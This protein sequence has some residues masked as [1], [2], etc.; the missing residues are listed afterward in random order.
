MREVVCRL[1]RLHWIYIDVTTAFVRETGSH[2]TVHVTVGLGN[3]R[4][5]TSYARK[6]PW[7]CPTLVQTCHVWFTPKVDGRYLVVFCCLLPY[8]TWVTRFKFLCVRKS[9]WTIHDQSHKVLELWIWI[10]F[11]NYQSPRIVRHRK[12]HRSTSFTKKIQHLHPP[13]INAVNIRPSTSIT[14]SSTCWLWVI[15]Q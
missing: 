1:P 12:S 7:T 8:T 14:P 3:T 6:S 9:I 5:L 10:F 13:P 4:I 11:I 15:Y 2:H